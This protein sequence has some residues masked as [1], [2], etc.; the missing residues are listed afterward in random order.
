ALEVREPGFPFR[1]CITRANTAERE[2]P[3]A[4]G[5]ARI[6]AQRAGWLAVQAEGPGW[7]VTVQPWYPGWAARVDGESAPVEAV[8]G[9]LVGVSLTSGT[10]LIVLQ[11]APE[12][13]Q[14]GLLIS[15]TS[16]LLLLAAWWT[17]RHWGGA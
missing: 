6:L 12:G 14:L 13:F 16:A 15:G 1:A 2:S 3:L 4:P 10:H 11:Y 9:A 5:P 17:G 7:L 8:D